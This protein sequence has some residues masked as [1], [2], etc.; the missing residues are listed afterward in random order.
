MAMPLLKAVS[1]IGGFTMLSRIFGF[2]RDILVARYLGAGMAADA[3]FVAFKIPNFLRRLFAEGAFNAAFVPLFAGTLESEG[4]QEA[5]HFAEEIAAALASILLLVVALGEI[6]MP[7]LLLLFAPGFV[8]DP[9]KYALTVFFT[10]LTFPYIL[11]ISLTTLLSGILN[12]LER[13]AAVAATP[14]LLNL[15]LISCLTLLS[16]HLPNPAYALAVGVMLAGLV[17]W[18]WLAIICYRHGWLPRI[19]KPH[20]TRR[21]KRL[22]ALAA[23]AAFGA[24]VAQVNLLV[25]I[26]LASLFPG[27]VAWLFYA[28]R[29]VELP[30]GVVGVAVGTALLPML[31][32]RIR[33]GAQAEAIDILNQ[34]LLMALALTLPATL[35]LMVIPGPLV[36]TIFEHGEFTAQDSLAVTPA[37]IAYAAGLPAF[38]LIKLFSPGFFAREDTKTPVKVAVFC[39]LINVVANLTLMQY[40][41]HIG[42][43]MATSISGWM[44]ALLLGF[45]LYKRRQFQPDKEFFRL[46]WRI[47]LASTAMTLLLCWLPQQLNFTTLPARITSLTILVASGLLSYMAI[48]FASGAGR[49]LLQ[50][51]ASA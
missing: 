28:D 1:T 21:V 49:K 12:S 27:A 36:Q 2:L 51:R 13:F 39:V 40:Y 9:E 17:Q 11:F 22:L 15:C 50:L 38:I 29:L 31:S 19:R 37:M 46:L 14:V 10:R 24:G 8:D 7:W 30:I 33:A 18:L 48:L 3:F 5:R 16:P 32:K 6:F 45:I 4:P 42:L 43:A 20:I 44:N 25:D 26:M 34:A 23:P 47:I 41:Q 35:A